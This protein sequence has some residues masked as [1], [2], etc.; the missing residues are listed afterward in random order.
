M[1]LQEYIGDYNARADDVR[2]SLRDGGLVL[3]VTDKGG[4]PTP[5]APPPPT[6]PPPVRAAFY[7]PDKI[8][9]RDEPYKDAHCEFLRDGNGELEWLRI[10]GR[11]HK[12]MAQ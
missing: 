12:K 5:A 9:L 10:F 6:Q 11:V 3:H 8:F 7:A 4:F 2:V 1:Q